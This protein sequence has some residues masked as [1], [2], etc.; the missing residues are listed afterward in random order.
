MTNSHPAASDPAAAMSCEDALAVFAAFRTDRQIVI[1]NMTT[2][3]IW[4]SF[5]RHPLDFHYLSSTMGG[6]IPLGL[7]IALARPD[8]EVV[9]LSGDGSL[10]MNLGC[11]ATIRAAG[12]T[13][14]TILLLDNGLYEVTGGQT[15]PG[16]LARLDYSSVARAF[17]F[18]ET[19]R[20][21]DCSAWRTYLQSP[22]T[23]IGPHFLTLVVRPVSAD[24]PR[25]T[26][27]QVDSELRRLRALIAETG[28]SDQPPRVSVP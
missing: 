17:G 5:S 15:T 11:L 24:T 25:C 1:S 12:V 16:R 18:P 23:E 3:R 10:L 27:S 4:P 20:F 26:K 2:A 9:V 28:S 7:G 8:F 19:A 6:A 22:E 21:D 13:N 14:L